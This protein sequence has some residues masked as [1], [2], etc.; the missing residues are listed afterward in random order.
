MGRRWDRLPTFFFLSFF[1]SP[2]DFSLA[3]STHLKEIGK[4]VND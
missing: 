2:E 3:G 1:S 4:C